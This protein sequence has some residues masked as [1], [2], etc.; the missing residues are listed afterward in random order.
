MALTYEDIKAEFE[1]YVKADKK[2]TELYTQIY[3]GDATYATAT[4]FANRI[5]ED[6]AVVLMRHAPYTDISEW[7]LENLLPPALGKNHRMVS[8]ACK[9][10]QERLNKDA[11]LGIKYQEA[12]FNKDKVYGMVK[13]LRDNP[14][15]TNIEQTFKDQLVNF[16][17]SV[18]DDTIKA[19]ANMLWKAGVKSVVVRVAEAKCCKW[20]SAIAGVYDYDQVSDTGNDVWR[21]HEN[22]NCTID[23]YTE[24]NGGTYRNRVK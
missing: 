6:L 3:Y 18:V 19:N 10:I 13:E 11:G 5:G 24:R 12:A 23:F 16:S 14:E 7:D 17:E 4:R 20:C 22:C 21:R 2:A 1:A 9:Q 8:E 15:F